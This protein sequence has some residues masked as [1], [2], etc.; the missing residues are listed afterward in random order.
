MSSNDK[1]QYPGHLQPVPDSGTSAAPAMPSPEAQDTPGLTQPLHR[2]HSRGFITDVLVELGYV[3][4]EVVQAAIEAAR[5]A[6]RTPESLLLE[7]GAIND[8][9]LSR[10]TA[11]RYGLDHVDLALY[12]VD[13]AARFQEHEGG[14]GDQHDDD[15]DLEPRIAVDLLPHCATGALSSCSMPLARW[16]PAASISLKS[17]GLE[18]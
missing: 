17:C 6:G 10:A 1:F 18:A 15:P 12:S 8:E 9:Q 7:Q 14:S 3:S 13:V 4:A 11:E 5:T 16:P 2:G